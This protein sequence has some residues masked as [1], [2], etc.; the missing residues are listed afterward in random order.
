MEEKQ[1]EQILEDF[2]E[3]LRR[4]D[5]QYL[6]NLDNYREEIALACA[7]TDEVY[8]K[9]RGVFRE[10]ENPGETPRQSDKQKILPLTHNFLMGLLESF[11]ELD[12][13]VI[14]SGVV[15]CTMQLYLTHC[16]MMGNDVYEA[17]EHLKKQTIGELERIEANFKSQTQK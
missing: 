10:D 1:P 7:P 3:I 16:T 6:V 15:S 5:F 9:I 8:E 11:G 13:G 12:D 2:V 17:I 14:L 4:D